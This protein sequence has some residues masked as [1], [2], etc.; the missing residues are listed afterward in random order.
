MKLS[1]ANLAR[2]KNEIVPQLVKRF[3]ETGEPV[4]LNELPCW[5]GMYRKT[6]IKIGRGFKQLVES[7]EIDGIKFAGLRKDNN[8]VYVSTV[9]AGSDKF[10][11]L[12][13]IVFI[14]LFFFGLAA[15]KPVARDVSSY[16]LQFLPQ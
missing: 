14:V 4:S 12:W 2:I 15:L 11:D 9:K 1:P 13:F 16:I 10:S 5:E 6:R 3:T 7:G 8:A